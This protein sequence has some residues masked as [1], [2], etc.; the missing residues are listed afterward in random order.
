MTTRAL[1]FR[2]KP[3]R[4]VESAIQDP[5]E[6]CGLIQAPQMVLRDF[7]QVDSFETKTLK[8]MNE[9]MLSMFPKEEAIEGSCTGVRRT[10]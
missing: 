3:Y 5:K 1:I 10:S 9:F 2:S 8:G 4:F 6:L 7:N